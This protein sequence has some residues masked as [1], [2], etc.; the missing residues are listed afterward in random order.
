MSLNFKLGAISLI[1]VM[2]GYLSFFALRY[3]D[4]LAAISSA[5]VVGG[6]IVISMFLFVFAY[7]ICF[8]V[9]YLG[10][11]KKERNVELV[12]LHELL[13][14]IFESLKFLSHDLSPLER[15]IIE[16]RLKRV[17][18]SEGI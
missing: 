1:A 15:S 4:G 18:F 5:Y 9:Y 12:I 3:Y 13:D 10:R 11:T 2:L 16:I 7:L 17:R 6:V 14:I 8:C